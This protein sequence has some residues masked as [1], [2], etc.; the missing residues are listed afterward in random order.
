[1]YCY[2]TVGE[3]LAFL[4][5][6]NLILEFVLCKSTFRISPHTLENVHFSG[7]SSVARGY[8]GYVDELLGNPMRNFFSEYLSME[9][10]YMADYPDLF[11]FI[12]VLSLTGCFFC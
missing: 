4:M 9:A 2:V 10:K 3:G 11:A 8:S 6:W 12:L 7:T 1:M 5:G